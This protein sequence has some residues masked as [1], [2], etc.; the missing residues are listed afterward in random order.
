[1]SLLGKVFDIF[2]PGH[3]KNFYARDFRNAYTFRP[4]QNPPRQKFQGYVNFI[5]NRSLYADT[6][7]GD[8]INSQ[9][10][11]QIGS[12]VRT[13]TL[14][15]V[16]FKTETKNEYNR[17]RIVNTGVEYQPVDIKV[18]D[19][20]NN[21]WLT[22][23]MKYFSYHYLNPRSKQYGSDQRDVGE[24]PTKALRA[25][26]FVGAK[27]GAGSK[28]DSNQFGYNLNLVSNFFERID[29]VIYHGNKGVQ[30]SLINPVLT[31]FR[32]GEI[33]YASSDVM[34]FD[35]SFE[36]ESFTIHETVNFG[37]SDFDIARFED[38]S[39]FKGPAF[40]PDGMPLALDKENTLGIL[41][42]NYRRTGQ[43]QNTLLNTATPASPTP[44]NETASAGP[45]PI[46]SEL[47]GNP[48]ANIPRT[49]PPQETD[50]A[51]QQG[52]SNEENKNQ[53]NANNASAT[54][55]NALPSV[56]GNKAEFA[57][58]TEKEKSW[59]G[60]LLSNVADQALTAAIHGRSIKDAV[61]NT[62]VGG[63]VQG[64]TDIV[65]T[66]VR[67]QKTQPTESAV[68]P[69]EKPISTPQPQNTPGG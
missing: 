11:L 5:I 29:Y 47:D 23:F 56:Y 59:L 32:T 26:D 33:D 31:R 10:R 46:S 37:L 54:Q 69:Q 17:K 34:E 55:K 60:G 1:M 62:A 42:K 45:P 40:V 41:S 15:E 58:P 67:G 24:D 35:L 9:F 51:A 4:D 68:Q 44:N 36:Y 38:A 3:N 64:I 53:A 66:P 50:A 39:G 6:L 14:P 65:Q 28:W 52:R 19:T 25:N 61:V 7:Y 12:L 48:E 18:F 43:P 63:V 57:K 2:G 8:G 20:I 22:L 21:E 16:E 49:A 30:Y 27:F 13:A